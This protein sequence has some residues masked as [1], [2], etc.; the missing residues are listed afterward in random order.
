MML[1]AV[2]R[3]LFECFYFP[4]SFFLKCCLTFRVCLIKNGCRAFRRGSLSW[5]E[6]LNK[7][8]I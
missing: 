6:S 5:E 3:S 8:R 2:F 1:Y 7:E 4:F